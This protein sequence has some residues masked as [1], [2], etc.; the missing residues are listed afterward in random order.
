MLSNMPNQVFTIQQILDK[1]KSNDMFSIS[2][3]LNNSFTNKN[4]DNLVL[5]SNIVIIADGAANKLVD[6][7][8]KLLNKVNFVIGDFDSISEKTIEE[9][10][11]RSSITLERSSC[12]NTT[13]LQKCFKLVSKEPNVKP[14]GEQ[15][16]Y[17]YIFIIGSSGGRAD[18]SYANLHASSLELSDFELVNVSMNCMT[19]YLSSGKSEYEAFF[20]D[21]KYRSSIVLFNDYQHIDPDEYITLNMNYEKNKY[22]LKEELDLSKKG[23]LY[24]PFEIDTEKEFQTYCKLSIK[25]NLKLENSAC[26]SRRIMVL[27]NTVE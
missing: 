10:S 12:Q 27:L 2:I 3:I 6:S 18:H 14:L 9:L 22:E 4:L 25:Y 24:K 1:Q 26:K 15:Y 8:S 16:K 23:L 19:Y 21:G 11:T 17:K 20:E 7:N 13:D 5:Q